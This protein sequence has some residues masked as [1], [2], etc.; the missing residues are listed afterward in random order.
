VYASFFLFSFLSFPL[1]SFCSSLYCVKMFVGSKFGFHK[2]IDWKPTLFFE[3]VDLFV[4]F[5]SVFNFSLKWDVW[6]LLY[7]SYIGCCSII[8]CHSHCDIYTHMYVL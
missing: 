6:T 2:K 7:I 8:T 5:L 3:A 4:W 1:L